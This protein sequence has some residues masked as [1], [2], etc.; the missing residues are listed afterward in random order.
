MLIQCTKKLLDKMNI[1]ADKLLSPGEQGYSPDSLD[2]WQAN[3]VNIDRRKTI[4]LMNNVARYPVVIYRPKP[5]DFSRM[6]ELIREAIATALRME[7][8]H[9]NVINNYLADADEI[10]FSKTANRSLVARMN[11]AAREV[12][13]MGEYLDEST[14]IQRYI[15][16]VAGRLIQSSSLDES[17][18]PIE[19][20]LE[21]LGNYG[22]AAGSEGW[23]GV[24]DVELYQLKVQIE[25]EGFNIWRRVLVPSTYSFRHLHNV[26]QTVFDW[27]NYHLHRF[28]VKKQGLKTRQIVMDDHPETLEWLDIDAHDV[29]QERF[30]A[31]KD[32]FPTYRRAHYEYDFGDSWEHTITLEKIVRAGE[33]KAIYLEGSGERPPEDVGGPGGYEEYIRIMADETDPEHETMKTWAESQ[34]ERELSP[35]K[36]NDRLRQALG[37]YFFY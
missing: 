28:E 12:M 4:I 6:E 17:F 35:E 1:P 32:I 16:M 24:L 14:L 21:H 3:I 13:F 30:T 7:G 26:I 20:L 29:L 15:S 5:K 10:R 9:E 33:F 19:K 37:Q 2:A 8:V 34:K 27:Q 36:I 23:T 18:Y 25:I 31:L 22:K 11:N